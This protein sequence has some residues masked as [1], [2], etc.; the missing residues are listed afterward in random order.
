MSPEEPSCSMRTDGRTG[1]QTD[2][3]TRR[4]TNKHAEASSRF[5]NICERA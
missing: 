5:W 3:Q 2:R 4:Q 1:R